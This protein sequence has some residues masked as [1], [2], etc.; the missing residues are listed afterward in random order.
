MKRAV[1]PGLASSSGWWIVLGGAA[2]N[3]IGSGF[4]FYS[5]NA[6]IIPLSNSFGVS[7]SAMAAGCRSPVSR[8]PLSGRSR[9][10]SWTGTARGG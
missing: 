3:A 8:A 9:D 2:G 10:T 7:L 6:F 4:N 1:A 5:L